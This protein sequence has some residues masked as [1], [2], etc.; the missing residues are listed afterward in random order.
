MCVGVADVVTRVLLGRQP[1]HKTR[2]HLYVSLFAIARVEASPE[3][4]PRVHHAVWV[5]VWCR[6]VTWLFSVLKHAHPIVLEDH[7]VVVRVGD[8]RIQA[9]RI[10]PFRPSEQF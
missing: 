2:L 7:L 5:R 9:H 4:T 10:L 1:A 3:G 8:T 6:L